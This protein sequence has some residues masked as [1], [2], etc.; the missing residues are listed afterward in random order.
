VTLDASTGFQPAQS[1]PSI[2]QSPAG[3]GGFDGEL[4]SVRLGM[5]LPAELNDIVGVSPYAGFPINVVCLLEFGVGGVSY[6]AEVDWNQGTVFGVSASFVRVSALVGP[7]TSTSF[8]P[9]INF[10]L[11]A[12]LAYGDAGNAGMSSEARRT[13]NLGDDVSLGNKLAAGATSTVVP[14]PLWAVGLTLVDSGS[15]PA[16]AP[17]IPDYTINLFDAAGLPSAMYKMINRTNVANQLEGQ[18]P[19]PLQARFISITN[20][21]GV[22]TKAPRLI[23]NLA[24]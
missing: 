17:V 7:I 6:T 16:L 24:L 8:P 10:T 23:F 3:N 11:Q 4:I 15:F 18:F 14:I 1:V 21:L 20:N 5:F 22:A 9:P 2:V 12:S 19:V 13:F